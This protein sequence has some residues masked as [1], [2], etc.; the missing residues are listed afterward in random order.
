M[1]YAGVVNARDWAFELIKRHRDALDDKEIEEARILDE[2]GDG[3]LAAYDLFCA[4][5]EDGWLTR[6]DLAEALRL[7][8]EKQFSKFSEGVERQARDLLAIL[9]A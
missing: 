4:G 8:R 7:A 9:A 1:R 5:I 3:W 6:A 2:D